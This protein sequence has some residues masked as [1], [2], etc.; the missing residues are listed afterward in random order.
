MS[1]INEHKIEEAREYFLKRLCENDK[2]SSIARSHLGNI[3]LDEVLYMDDEQLVV[4]NDLASGLLYH[5]YYRIKNLRFYFGESNGK[6]WVDGGINLELEVAKPSELTLKNGVKFEYPK[7]EVE[8]FNRHLRYVDWHMDC[9]TTV[10]NLF[11]LVDLAIETML[12]LIERER[13]RK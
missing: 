8:S 5:Y 9:E 13:G 12:E 7:Y 1:L 4:I 6:L 10:N 11:E 2:L 3:I